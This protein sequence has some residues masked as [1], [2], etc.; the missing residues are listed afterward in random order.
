LFEQ[1]ILIPNRREKSFFIATAISAIINV[2]LNF[3][4]IPYIHEVGAAITTLIA[5]L[6]TMIYV[7]KGSKGCVDFKILKKD[8]ASTIMVTVAI[9]LICVLGNQYINFMFIQV[10]M[11]TL[12]SSVAYV[13][14]LKTMKNS[15]IDE[16]NR[17]LRRKI[18][19]KVLQ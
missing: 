5:E 14:I 17:I 9:V 3:F 4:L 12:L 13:I 16:V 6:I 7:I 15:V 1:C 11:C 19:F 8:I 10:V 18:H 2:G